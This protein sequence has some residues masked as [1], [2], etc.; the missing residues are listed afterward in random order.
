MQSWMNYMC[1]LY[2]YNYIKFQNL[3]HSSLVSGIRI[4]GGRSHWKWSLNLEILK[5]LGFL[6]KNILLFWEWVCE[7]VGGGRK[8][9]RGV[10]AMH[11]CEDQ[12]I[13]VWRWLLS[14]TFTRGV[15]LFARLA[16]WAPLPWAI[17]LAL[18]IRL[19]GCTHLVG[20]NQALHFWFAEMY[21]LYPNQHIV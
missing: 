14:S 17:L 16:Q 4:R 18:N 20:I 15:T 6:F 8:G 21:V 13:A 19:H 9:N 11:T 7:C 1:T 12:R 10:H 5:I 3:W 2:D